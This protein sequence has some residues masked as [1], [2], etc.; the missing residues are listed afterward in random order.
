MTKTTVKLTS[1]LPCVLVEMDIP[2]EWCI[3][4]PFQDE[5]NLK[6]FIVFYFSDTQDFNNFWQLLFLLKAPILHITTKD[7]RYKTR[8]RYSVIET[9]KHHLRSKI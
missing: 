7:S 8:S 3:L 1:M 4:K 9:V 2:T 5:L 6:L